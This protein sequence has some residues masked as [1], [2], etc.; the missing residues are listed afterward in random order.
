MRITQLKM[1]HS[2]RTGPGAALTSTYAVADSKRIFATKICKRFF[3]DLRME[4]TS[5]ATHPSAHF[6]HTRAKNA[7][8]SEIWR[9]GDGG[10]S[11]LKNRDSGETHSV[12][13]GSTSSKLS[14][15]LAVKP[16]LSSSTT[17]IVPREQPASTRQ[18]EAEPDE[19]G[20]ETKTRPRAPDEKYLSCSTTKKKKRPAPVK[21]RAGMLIASL[22]KDASTMDELHWSFA[23]EI[24]ISQLL[25]IL[26]K[27]GKRD[28]QVMFQAWERFAQIA[29][30]GTGEGAGEED[31]IDDKALL[32]DW[33]WSDEGVAS[34]LLGSRD[35]SGTSSEQETSISSFTY[36]IILDSFRKLDLPNVQACKLAQE[37]LLENED[38]S[39]PSSE[40][41]SHPVL[42]KS[43]KKYEEFLEA[44][45]VNLLGRF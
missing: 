13:S 28:S 22:Y 34:P 3:A 24:E 29:N 40:K 9:P 1:V 19:D 14:L 44:K 6:V 26:A 32:S 16:D 30:Q 27:H 31:E 38:R 5:K 39:A 35:Q 25:G 15:S 37:R 4:E 42:V 23:L 33:Q 43:L 7:Y 20:G 12:S 45:G 18:E 41:A 8:G 21:S 2:F 17:T 11:T 36:A 10:T